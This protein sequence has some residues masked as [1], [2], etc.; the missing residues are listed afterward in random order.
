MVTYKEFEIIKHLLR[1]QEKTPGA[2]LSY[3]DHNLRYPVFDSCKEVLELIAALQNKGYLTDNLAVT[4]LALREIEP[5]RVKNAFILAAGGS[6][7]S[8]KSVYSMPKGLYQKNDETLIER[9]IRQLQ[10]AGITDIHVVVGIKKEMYFYL[11][12][13]CG[14]TLEINP[15]P[16]KNN[17]YSIYAIADL[18]DNSYICNCDNYFAD[19]PFFPYEYA[20]FHATVHKDNAS[21]EL[22]VRKNESDRIT[23]VYNGSKGV[24]GEC[25]YGHAY[26]DAGFSAR[27]AP[28]CDR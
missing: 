6:D 20:S 2:F 5:C 12:E 14:V 17:I 1:S 25:V 11:E 24:S 10:E 3:L 19:N 26:F 7:I 4:E 15:Y 28:V 27:D 13:K 8:A 23:R 22:L 18:L 21:Q 9:Q 16:K